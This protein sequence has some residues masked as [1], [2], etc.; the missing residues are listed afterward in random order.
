MG[1]W[2]WQVRTDIVI[3]VYRG[4]AQCGLLNN[5]QELVLKRMELICGF[6]KHISRKHFVV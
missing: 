4:C 3:V 1:G 5:L 6:T 2:C